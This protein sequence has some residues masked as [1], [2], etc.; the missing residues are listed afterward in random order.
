VL[1]ISA[2]TTGTVDTILFCS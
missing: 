2:F 1:F